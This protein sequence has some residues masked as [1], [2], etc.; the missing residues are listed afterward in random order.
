M[1]RKE[2][3]LHVNGSLIHYSKAGRE[4][5]TFTEFLTRLIKIINKTSNLFT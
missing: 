1:T 2:K 3:E 4:F 5:S